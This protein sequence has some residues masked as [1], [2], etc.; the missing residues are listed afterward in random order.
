M[1]ERPWI[2]RI[3]TPRRRGSPAEGGREIVARWV[4]GFIIASLL[5]TLISPCFISSLS[6]YEWSPELNDYVLKAGSIQRKRDE[7]WATS[8]Y[9]PYG[10][11]STAGVEDST[12]SY[13]MI[14][15]DSYIEAQQVS[16]DQKAVCQ[17]NKTFSEQGLSRFRAVAVGHALWSVADYYFEIPK[18]ETLLDPVCHFIVL[19]EYGLKDLCP[20]EETFLSTPT[21]QFVHRSLVDPRKSNVVRDLYEC[22]FGDMF[23]APWK[24]VRT[25]SRDSRSMRFSLGPGKGGDKAPE[26]FGDVFSLAEDDPN[27]LVESWTYALDMLKTTTSRPIVLVLVPEVPRL[28]RGVV[29]CVDTQSQWRARLFEL[30]AAKQIGCI[31]MT[32]TL[33]GDYQTTGRLSRGFHNGRPASGH[34]NARGNW[35]LSQQICAYVNRHRDSL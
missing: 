8:H 14:W 20:D 17:V 25:L 35:L 28:E 9:G 5:V 32:D 26:D 27:A 1:N 2:V 15:G 31:D 33:V 34:L 19:A 4:L 6:V 10:F 16:D 3:G 13:V 11:N 30:C 7:G 18:Y 21:L 24:A 12:A 29:C 23:L 22:G